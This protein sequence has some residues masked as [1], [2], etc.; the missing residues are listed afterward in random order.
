MWTFFIQTHK[1]KSLTNTRFSYKIH[2]PL[3][4]A[5]VVFLKNWE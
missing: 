4:Y 3:F 2:L 1:A 5:L